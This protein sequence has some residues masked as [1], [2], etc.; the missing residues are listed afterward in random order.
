M[1]LSEI[2]V[3]QYLTEQWQ[4]AD[5]PPPYLSSFLTHSVKSPSLPTQLRQQPLEIKETAAQS[6]SLSSYV[7]PTLS[8]QPNHSLVKLYENSIQSSTPA[9]PKQFKSEAINTQAVESPS[10]TNRT[11]PTPTRSKIPQ[12]SNF[13][14]YYEYISGVSPFKG[15]RIVPGFGD[16]NAPICVISLIP[17]TT[18]M[19]NHLLHSGPEGELF[20]KILAAIGLDRKKIY[21]TSLWKNPAILQKLSLRDQAVHKPLVYRELELCQAKVWVLLGEKCCQYMLRSGKSLTDLR[22]EKKLHTIDTGKI[23]RTQIATYHPAELLKKTT[24]RTQAWDDWK[25]IRN[26]IN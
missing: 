11:S 21:A 25:W 4:I 1:N 20:D 19:Q 9:A 22:Q 17:S 13:Q 10:S 7:P 15:E 26:L 24:L 8:A 5:S 14:D 3:L 12:F 6:N 18:D 2:Q 23:S 16:I